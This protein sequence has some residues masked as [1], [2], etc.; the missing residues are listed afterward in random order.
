MAI[1]SNWLSYAFIAC[2]G[3]TGFGAALVWHREAGS[4]AELATGV[5]LIPRR[6][7]PDLNLI[8]DRGRRFTN[9]SLAGHWSLLYF[10]YTNCPDV[11]PATLATLAAMD[12]R[13]GVT[14]AATRP[15]VVFISVDAARDTPERL[16]AY[17]PYFDSNFLGVTAP[18]QASIEALAAKLG[19]AVALHPEPGGT[20]SVDHSSALFVVDPQGRVAAILTGPY[21]PTTLSS[22]L[23]HIA[24]ARS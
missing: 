2:A 20:Y 24:A 3:L 5:F 17:V 12:K 9:A 4:A 19:I 16:A 13:L 21:T 7:V 11:C 1:R 15:Q 22:D 23:Q 10:G 18:D 14:P 6:T 8:D